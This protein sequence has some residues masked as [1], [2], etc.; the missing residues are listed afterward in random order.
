[1]ETKQRKTTRTAGKRP[2]A[3]RERT[4][5]KKKTPRKPEQKPKISQ[6]VVYLP[7][8]PF[9][10]HRMVLRLATVVA[11]VVAVVLGMSVFF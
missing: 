1:M 2:A 3:T 6:D 9:S 4:Q 5:P 11:V 10:R 8:K 7:P